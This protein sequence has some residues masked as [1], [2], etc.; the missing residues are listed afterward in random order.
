M[1]DRLLGT[2]LMLDKHPLRGETL[3]KRQRYIDALSYGI[4][5][6]ETAQH[7]KDVLDL[8]RRTLIPEDNYIAKPAPW[9]TS[10]FKYRYVLYLDVLF[11][12]A[13]NNAN[14]GKTLAKRMEQCIPKVN[15][16]KL[17]Q[18]YNRLY[19][20]E[21][22]CSFRFAEAQIHIWKEN[23]R[24]AE[25][26]LTKVV[27]T[28][29]MSAGKSTLIN[30]IVGK[31]V[32]KSQN[33]ACTAK[34]HYIFNKPLED[35]FVAEDD[36]VY[37]LDADHYSLMTDDVSNANNTIKVGTY[38]RSSYLSQHRLCIIDTPGVN[39]STDETHRSITEESL[40]NEDG[41][42]LVYVING[43]SM[44][45]DDE[46]RYMAY[47]SNMNKSCPIVFVVNKVDRFK[48]DEDSI[49]DSLQ[50]IK[51]DVV[52]AGFKNAL[53][54]PVS[55]NAGLLAKIKLAGDRLSEDDI[56]ELDVLERKFRRAEYNLLQFFPLDVQEK[57]K[58]IVETHYSP[59]DKKYIQLLLN[60]GIL[61]VEQIL[62]Q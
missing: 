11:I 35:G 20:N 32:N 31:R 5:A 60:C 40:S 45:T 16:R 53:V 30:A 9:L 10:I 37:N 44:G 4:G 6:E 47:L 8:Y 62:I 12:A 14:E 48:R 33:D 34:L 52:Q 28:A 61:G 19:K 7:S 43:E 55:A 18:L 2:S 23:Q 27:F 22:S 17:W 29:N 3:K 50:Q 26:A 1:E 54:L 58:K 25:L 46:H 39:S 38:F 42:T 51:K 13:F 36:N 56:D 24:F 59:E 49:A 41:Y 21:V 15:R 57:C